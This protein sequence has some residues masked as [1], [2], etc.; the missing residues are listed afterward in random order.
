MDNTA[1]KIKMFLVDDHG[2]FRDGI[3]AMLTFYDD[4]EVVGEAGDGIE[5]IDKIQGLAP[6]IVLLDISMPNMNG[7]E[8][9]RRIK[10]INPNIKVIILTQYINKEYLV[11]AVKI[12]AAGYVPKKAVASDLVLAIRVVHDGDFFLHPAVA[13]ILVGDYRNMLESDTD[14][15]DSLTNRERE[16]LQLVAEGNTSR[17]IGELLHISEKTVIGHRASLMEKLNIHNRADLV[18]YAIGKGLIN[19]ENPVI[20]LD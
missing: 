8:V 4:L 6:D 11:T 16:I 15:Y 10:K 7:L 2:L 5:A 1:S 18:K 9:C 13:K 12:G 17:K 19:I 3:R 20:G 14:E